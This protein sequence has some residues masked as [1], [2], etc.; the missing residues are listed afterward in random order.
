MSN[1]VERLTPGNKYNHKLIQE[2]VQRYFFASKFCRDK[3]VL[4][5]GC[6]TGYGSHYLANNNAK[7]IV[8]LDIS[9]DAI[10]FAK[11]NYVLPNL[12]FQI[13][14]ALK[15][16][17]EDNS[18]DTII[19]FEIIEHVKDPF[20]FLNECIRIMKKEGTLILSTPNKE[21]SVIL[22]DRNPFHTHEFF[23]SEFEYLLQ[24]YFQEVNLYYQKSTEK[25]SETED[26]PSDLISM[27]SDIKE[28]HGDSL[29]KVVRNDRN[30][31]KNAMY[32][33]AVCRSPRDKINGK[34]LK[35][36]LESIHHKELSKKLEEIVAKEELNPMSQLLKIYNL[37][38]D[39]QQAYPEVQNGNY[40]RLLKWAVN[41]CKGQTKDY[42]TTEL[43][44][45]SQWYSKIDESYNLLND[46]ILEKKKT[47][48]H[49]ES[50]IEQ[51]KSL[52][53]VYE[54]Y[55]NSLDKQVNH[56]QNEIIFYKDKLESANSELVSYKDKLESANSELV[57][58]KDKL[59]SANSELVSYKDKLESANSELVS[60]KTEN[61]AIK[62]SF[63]FKLLRKIDSSFPE[64]T[65]RG[66]FR[67]I[68]VRSLEIASQ[69]GI[70][71]LF[72]QIG[73]KFRKR[74]FHIKDQRSDV[75]QLLQDSNQSDVVLECSE[76]VY[77]P[78]IS[79]L[80]PVYNSNLQWLKVAIDSVILQSYTNLELCICDDGSTSE[81]LQK[82]LKQYAQTD[83]RIKITRLKSNQGIVGATNKALKIATGDFIL[84][85]DHDDELAPDS[86]YE[87]VKVLNYDREIDF[88]Y[89]DE[90]KIDNEGKYVEPFY[91]PDFSLF[92]LQSM[93]YL[94]HVAVIR[95]RLVD[96]AGGFNPE[97][98]GAQDYDLF[99]RILER[100]NKVHH[101]RKILYHWRKS[102][103]SGAGNALA[104]PWIYEQG[105]SLLQ[106]H[107]KRMNID[108]KAEIGA[109]WGLYK[110]DYKISE[111]SP[112]D[113]LIPTRQISFLKKCV[114]SIKT[115][116]TWKNYKIWVIVNGNNDYEVI[117][118]KSMDCSEIKNRVD[119]TTGLIGPSL[120]Y[121]WSRMNN[122][123]VNDTN[124]PYMIFLNDD[125][126]IITESWIENMLQYAQQKDIGVVGVMLL[127]PDDLIQH[128]GDYIT[129]N[130]TGDHCFNRMKKD[131]FEVNGLAQVVRE[132]SA[133]T[134]ACYMIRREV[135]EKLGGY[136]E[137]LRNYDDYDLCL[138]MRENGYKII[139]TPY[140]RLY[141]HESPTRPQINDK[142]MLDMLLAKHPW[143][144]SD[145][146]YRYEWNSLYYKPVIQKSQ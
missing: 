124:S 54:K 134:S 89:S 24:N 22:R 67:K 35:A 56:F 26:A 87:I 1:Y 40:S 77:K 113:I 46:E 79:V 48:L 105:K 118:I 23:I 97:F 43:R 2:H 123:G 83:R 3:K 80:M 108:A 27:P 92:L 21:F 76:F 91:K 50:Q 42:S 57:S 61:H 71:N 65:S 6:G 119:P 49:L 45:F 60:Y 72:K 114:K 11:K 136:D 36:A 132:T 10:S 70:S 117:E 126:E 29:Q 8:G 144:R 14:D 106:S 37:R 9:N 121:N 25:Q 18:F 64:E 34:M 120:P 131:S 73:T 102:E 82:F 55:N 32:F 88:I 145:S 62:N 101:I 103:A 129:K 135:F 44:K 19:A 4:D 66:E 109:G 141:H 133:V 63:T 143:A 68:L 59:E 38:S 112:V 69:Q 16:K 146:F 139:Y 86:M 90:D 107:L 95:K 111:K 75:Q 116:T 94:I 100:T 15:T 31:F 85:L 98:E 52:L 128:A 125:T 74:E 13:G 53:G 96:E 137:K 5:I 122:I 140:A 47:I 39:L 81:E 138:R 12:S 99:F 20:H 78:K 30:D 110:T 41:T 127:Y 7:N 33:V 130:G 17:F 84:L 58:Y 51:M 142:S 115:K 104:K 28:Q 93:N